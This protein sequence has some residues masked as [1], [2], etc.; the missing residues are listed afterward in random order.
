VA[1]ISAGKDTDEIRKMLSL[2]EE[3][4]AEVSSSVAIA[5]VRSLPQYVRK[6]LEDPSIV[7]PDMVPPLAFQM[8]IK[9]P[10]IYNRFRKLKGP[11][12]L[13]KI[14]KSRQKVHNGT[15]NEHAGSIT[16]TEQVD[17]MDIGGSSSHSHHHHHHHH[18]GID[19][20]SQN[21][22][23]GLEELGHIGVMPSAGSGMDHQFGENTVDGLDLSG[24]EMLAQFAD[25]SGHS[26]LAQA[27][28]RLPSGPNGDNDDASRLEEEVMKMAR[29]AAE[30]A[31]AEQDK[32]DDEWAGLDGM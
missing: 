14:P 20:S 32:E 11:I 16:P 21:Q 3:E 25:Q 8:K 15:P 31:A 18:H 2:T 5:S 13:I 23:L 10:D 7:T 24:H 12:R 30:N 4:K 22:H 9:Y 29:M 26:E 1:Q 17:P 27:L 6:A 19:M 28:M